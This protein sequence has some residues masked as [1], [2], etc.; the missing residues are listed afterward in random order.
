L[1][2][3]ARTRAQKI[4]Q[5]DWLAQQMEDL[6]GR[7]QRDRQEQADYE[8]MQHRI[9][10]VQ[11]EQQQAAMDE[12]MRAR[13]EVLEYNKQQAAFNRNQQAR[14][15]QLNQQQNDAE[16]TTAL[17]GQFLN[18]AVLI[19]GGA[20]NFKGF[21]TEQRQRILDEQKC[22]MDDIRGMVFPAD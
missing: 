18:E 19:R 1:N 16:L 8:S 9:V 2:N 17:N 6:Q 22:Q 21:S 4:Q 10:Q 20:S 7:E 5:Q 12:R 3:A 11:G 14:E 15:A 13:R